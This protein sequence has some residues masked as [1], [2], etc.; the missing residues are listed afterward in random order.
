MSLLQES[1]VHCPYCGESITLL[2]DGSVDEQ[3]Y[4]EDCEVCCRPMEVTVRVSGDGEILVQVQH[5]DQV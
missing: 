3:H 4:V 2:V 1:A 5:E